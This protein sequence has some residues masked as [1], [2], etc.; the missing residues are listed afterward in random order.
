M[1]KKSAKLTKFMEDLHSFIVSNP[2]FRKKTN[3]KNEAQIQTEI[4]PLLIQFLVQYFEEAG[5]QD[6]VAKANKSFY[7]EGQEGGVWQ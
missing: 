4:R 2:Q 7:W 1:K 6:S 3:E 5:Y